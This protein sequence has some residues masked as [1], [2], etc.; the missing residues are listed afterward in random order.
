MLHNHV[1]YNCRVL[2]LNRK[3][4]LIR[5]KTVLAD[6]G[7]YREC[8]YFTSWKKHTL[9][10]HVLSPLLRSITGDVSVPIGCAVLQTSEAKVASEICEEL[11]VMDRYKVSYLGSC[12]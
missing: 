7:N 1:R 5:P 9:E 10:K 8:R 2:C 6:D 12:Y 4:L 3:I 11:W